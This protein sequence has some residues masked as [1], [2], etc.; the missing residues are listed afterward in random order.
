MNGM[1]LNAFTHS[2]FDWHFSHSQKIPIGDGEYAR[3]WDTNHHMKVDG[4][5][6]D[7]MCIAEGQ[8]N[9]HYE[10]DSESSFFYDGV[11]Y[12][13]KI[14]VSYL[15]EDRT[16]L[17]YRHDR[18]RHCRQ[19]IIQNGF[20]PVYV[21]LTPNAFPVEGVHGDIPE[22]N[23]RF[24]SSTDTRR[25]KG[26]RRIG[27]AETFDMQGREDIGDMIRRYYYEVVCA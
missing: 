10:D 20:T 18:D 27:L 26:R 7:L 8:G 13:R 3:Y 24:V 11:N 22:W 21:I 25:K 2:G 4:I 5:S 9:Y 14:P 16:H 17:G 12:S 23:R 6:I 19:A 1:L 15:G